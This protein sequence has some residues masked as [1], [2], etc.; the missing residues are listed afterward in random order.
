MALGA[1][2]LALAG[3][4]NDMEKHLKSGAGLAKFKEMIR[5]QDG[6]PEAKLP[7]AKYERPIVAIKSGFVSE[8]LCD[9]LG[10]AVIALGGGRKVASDQI[11]FAVGFEHPK[12]IGDRVEKGQPLIIMHYNDLAKAEEAERIISASYVISDHPVPKI[13]N[14]VT[15]KVV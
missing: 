8:I 13:E 4:P 2:M 3:K 12:K 1:E 10:Y 9:Q 15:R 6:D 5:A 11:D 7:Q 14:L